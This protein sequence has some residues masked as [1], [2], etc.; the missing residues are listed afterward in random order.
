MVI[1]WTDY[2]IRNCRNEVV[3]NHT[4]IYW[5]DYFNRN[6]VYERINLMDLSL[7]NCSD[8]FSIKKIL[9]CSVQFIF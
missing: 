9:K 2:F 8:D 7:L 4:V 1:Y 3:Y 6:M 5:A